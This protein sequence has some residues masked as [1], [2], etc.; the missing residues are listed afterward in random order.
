MPAATDADA[1]AAALRER[2][3]SGRAASTSAAHRQLAAPRSPTRPHGRS[4]DPRAASPQLPSSAWAATAAGPAQ[5][6]CGGSQIAAIL[7]GRSQTA[8]VPSSSNTSPPAWAG[9]LWS[10]PASAYNQQR[11]QQQQPAWRAL[12]SGGGH[13][14]AADGQYG[15]IRPGPLKLES[16]LYRSW[17]AA[18]GGGGGD[19]DGV[20]LGQTQH[21][22]QQ[23]K[24]Q[25]HHQQQ[26]QPTHH[27]HQQQQ[28]QQHPTEATASSPERVAS[29]SGVKQKRAGWLREHFGSPRPPR[30]EDAESLR[31]WL[32]TQLGAQAHQQQQQQVP[33][34]VQWQTAQLP[35]LGT[36]GGGPYGCTAAAAEQGDPQPGC[37][38]AEASQPLLCAPVF[39]ADGSLDAA[40]L[41]QQAAVVSAAF[42][43]L[44]RQVCVGCVERG[45][46]MR[47]CWA[48][49][50]ALL[51]AAVGDRAGALAAADAAR[52]G[53]AAAGEAAA[54]ARRR[55]QEE[56]TA[57]RAMMERHAAKA[58]E[59]KRETQDWIDK[60]DHLQLQLERLS[61]AQRLAAQVVDLEAANS[62]LADEGARLR[63]AL[64]EANA[65][66]EVARSSA[67][68][69]RRRAEAAEGAA[70]ELEQRL[71]ACTPR[72]QR[73]MGLLSDLLSEGELALVEQALIAG[74]F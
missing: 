34:P 2:A 71:G 43:E 38:D 68:D 11:Q 58:A 67:E 45:R 31:I 50:R 57:L 37:W 74:G 8:P 62:Q 18:E 35:E 10:T 29:P 28:Q 47:Q 3:A 69:A 40:A 21:Q 48:A 60:H 36:G 52:A 25:D 44:C 30:R 5:Q 59:S 17:V 13:A 24:Q 20:S 72:P 51:A 39:N 32:Q 23:Q 4:P 6:Q 12:V 16:S 73:D 61:N 33:V 19:G 26:Q 22:E 54:A 7:T 55:A 14:A 46:L 15:H 63:A 1:P 64:S 49:L 42:G 41:E 70:E 66:L 56:T 53:E 27:H 65:D 9:Q